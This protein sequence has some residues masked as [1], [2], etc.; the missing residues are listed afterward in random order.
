MFTIVLTQFYVRHVIL[1]GPNH[2]F[3]NAK[4]ETLGTQGKVINGEL[5]FGP[6]TVGPDQGKVIPGKKHLIIRHLKFKVSTFQHFLPELN[7]FWQVGLPPEP[8]FL[9]FTHRNVNS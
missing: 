2:I 8:S 5:S 6:K 1:P 9:V 7:I 4:S 3:W